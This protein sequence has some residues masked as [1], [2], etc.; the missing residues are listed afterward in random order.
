[1]NQ[2]WFLFSLTVGLVAYV[3]IAGDV[4]SAALL[5]YAGLVAFSAARD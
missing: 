3:A 1:M 5:A 2:P 4:L